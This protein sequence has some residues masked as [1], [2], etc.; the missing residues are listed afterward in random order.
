MPIIVGVLRSGTTSLRLMLDAH[1]ELAIPPE[2]ERLVEHRSRVTNEGQVIISHE[3]RL[4]Q[5][6]LTM[7]PV[8]RQRA[9]NWRR[10]MTQ[11]EQSGF[12]SVAGACL[13]EFG[14][15]T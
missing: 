15:S 2:T 3:G 5:Q 6:A 1:Q 4:Q 9:Q 10:T 11:V 8:C 14:Y 13:E 12:I 7:Q